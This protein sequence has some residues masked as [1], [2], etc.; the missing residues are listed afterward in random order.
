MCKFHFGL[1]LK[2]LGIIR[3]NMEKS[4]VVKEAERLLGPSNLATEARVKSRN[5][6]LRRSP[7]QII[8]DNC[9]PTWPRW[10]PAT[11]KT[12]EQCTRM[13]R[14]SQQCN[15]LTFQHSSL[16]LLL[17]EKWSELNNNMQRVIWILAYAYLLE[18]KCRTECFGLYLYI[19]QVLHMKFSQIHMYPC[20]IKFG[21]TYVLNIIHWHMYW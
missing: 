13:P 18:F 1:W 7:D 2:I 21:L 10:L 16:V 19:E 4:E 11:Y 12:R 9:I 20:W 17:V 3:P 15:V 14:T 6:N 5:G 8:L